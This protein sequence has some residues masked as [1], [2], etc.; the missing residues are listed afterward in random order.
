MGLKGRIKLGL[1]LVIFVALWS[2]GLWFM[3]CLVYASSIEELFTVLKV[4]VL[5]AMSF[6][7]GGWWEAAVESK[8]LSQSPKDNPV[9]DPAGLSEKR[10]AN[11]WVGGKIK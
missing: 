2:Y 11:W 6:E 10:L 3:P 9:T 1:F 5:M 4:L 8:L 7:V